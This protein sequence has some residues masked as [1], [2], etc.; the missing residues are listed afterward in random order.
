MC[1]GTLSGW[2]VTIG[3]DFVISLLNPISRVEIHIAK[4]HDFE[5]CRYGRGTEWFR[6][7]FKA[8]ILK[9]PTDD[10]DYLVDQGKRFPRL[11]LLQE[12][13]RVGKSKARVSVKLH[14]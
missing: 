3:P 7:L 12:S 2:L 14:L 10:G 1:W 4:I 8:V 6:L 11:R 9:G 5:G 13:R